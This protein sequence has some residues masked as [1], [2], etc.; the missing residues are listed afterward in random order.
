MPVA[1]RPCL[2]A[3]SCGVSPASVK[4]A[5]MTLTFPSRSLVCIVAAVLLQAA[6][7]PVQKDAAPPLT[8][9]E[10]LVWMDTGAES[11]RVVQLVERQGIDFTPKAEFLED[12]RRL[13]SKPALLEKLQNARPLGPSADPV[14]EQSAYSHLLACLQGAKTGAS[15]DENK[16]CLAAESGEPA[17]ARFAL[18]NRALL[19]RQ[20]T[21]AQELFKKAI[22]IAPLIPDNHNYLGLAFQRAGNLKVAEA[23]YREA[24]RLDPDYETPV[25]NLASVFLDLNDPERAESYARHAVVMPYSSAMAHHHLGLALIKQSKVHEGMAELFEAARLEPDSPFHHVQIA[26]MLLAGRVYELA[27]QQYREAAALDPSDVQT[28]RRILQVL[29]VLRRGDEAMSECETLSKLVPLR[30]GR[31]CKDI[32]RGSH[33]K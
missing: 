3:F 27:L 10:V 4:S 13:H 16:E 33:K 7:K 15:S 28:H 22:E 32:V 26:E 23:E 11:V 18:G 30:E 2:E 9:G 17:A 1:V 21:A 8:M 24:M 12:L 14:F 6:Q 25:S 29:L 20:F 5:Q 31:S 19:A